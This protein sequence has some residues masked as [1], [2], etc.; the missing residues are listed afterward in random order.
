MA[1]FGPHAAAHG[2]CAPS[3][4][5]VLLTFVTML[6]RLA[7][8]CQ[9]EGRRTQIMAERWRGTLGFV[10]DTAQAPPQT[11]YLWT[12]GGH[13][14]QLLERGGVR[15][16]REYINKLV[17][18][19]F[20]RDSA[21][22]RDLSHDPLT[23]MYDSGTD[24]TPGF[25]LVDASDPM[26]QDGLASIAHHT[27]G[28]L[29][30]AMEAVN[31]SAPYTLTSEAGQPIIPALI[32]EA[33]RLPS[34]AALLDKPDQTRLATTI[35]SLES[36]GT[37]FHRT[38]S[39]A[40]TPG[41][42]AELMREAAQDRIPGL[43]FQTVETVDSPQS[44]VVA[45]IPGATDD[46]TT[47][48]IG[49]HLDSI[50]SGGASLAAPGADDD[51]SGVATLV[52]VLRVIAEAGVRFQ[53]RVEF[54]A[55]GAEEVGLEGSITLAQAY[56]ADKRRVA[57]MLQV[58]MNAWS[59]ASDP[60]IHFVTTS[61]TPYLTRASKDL[62]HSYLGGNFLSAALTAGTSDHKSWFIRGFPAVFPFEK[63]SRYNPAIH[64]ARDTLGALTNLPLAR[65]FS[66]LVLAFL[67][68]EAGIVA[69]TGTM[70]QATQEARTSLGKDLKIAI[71]PGLSSKSY[72]VGI[73]TGDK[74]VQ[75][76]DICRG[77]ER[78]SMICTHE[79]LSATG[80]DVR[81][82][83]AL[84]FVETELPLDE[85]DRLSVFGYDQTEKLVAQ[86]T[87]KLTKKA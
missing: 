25:A 57:G 70:A 30:G 21:L 42:V 80:P 49:A 43:G 72:T 28:H 51:A 20:P 52:E 55:Y 12:R 39:G 5:L 36:L 74:A 46:A 56:A 16:S 76:V 8:G 64:S 85:G 58:D 11:R 4:I 34:V 67:A 3:K 32:S 82:D 73:G 45:S 87:V 44:S 40:A 37:R 50:N 77:G 83:R 86:R 68:H 26:I 13:G 75:S 33:V 10:E 35:Q 23:Q 9:P 38:E 71:I 31:L 29:C 60:V 59:E 6:L 53:R 7:S 24:S 22:G 18:V 2:R 79:R 65:R 81:Q 63:P 47:V 62:M 66:Q 78:G 41:R 19:T 14:V 27:S 48:I 17:M 84:F 1:L 54:H 15:G 69:E 61:T